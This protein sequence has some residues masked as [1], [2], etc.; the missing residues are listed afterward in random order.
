MEEE[1]IRDE[2]G[3]GSCQ[4]VLGVGGV[5]WVSLNVLIH[6]TYHIPL[7]HIGLCDQSPDCEE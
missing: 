6:T 3:R 1:V 4:L 7:G 5:N 2:K